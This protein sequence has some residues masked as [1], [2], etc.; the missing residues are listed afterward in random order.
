[1]GFGKHGMKTGGFGGG[2][3]FEIRV[4]VI[5][6]SEK[7]DEMRISSNQI[8][9]DLE[10]FQTQPPPYPK[11]RHLS[12]YVPD[13]RRGDMNITRLAGVPSS[14]FT[15]IQLIRLS[16]QG[17]GAI[18][19]LLAAYHERKQYE[20]TMA[21]L[22][23]ASRLWS[24]V[25]DIN[26]VYMYVLLAVGLPANVL[27]LVTILTMH[28]VTPVAILIASLA[29]VDGAALIGKF[30]GMQIF[31]HE[32]HV[33]SVGC[34]MEFLILFMSTMA[35]WILAYISVER[36]VS[37][38][39][40]TKKEIWLKK[41]NIFVA[42]AATGSALLVIFASVSL[43]MRD[44]VRS[45]YQCGVYAEFYWFY[46]YVWYWIN[47]TLFL[48]LPCSMVLPCTAMAVARFLCRAADR[49][50]N[51]DESEGRP[52]S[53]RERQYEVHLTAMMLIA[54]IFFILLCL[55]ACVYYL[56]YNNSDDM[57]VE[58][59]WAIFEQVQFLLVDS[60]HAINF[61]IYFASSRVFRH[62]LFYLLTCRK[63]K[64]LSGE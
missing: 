8:F 52:T 4:K 22:D 34:K 42:L 51:E 63:Y 10:V 27:A 26:R 21:E 6:S 15:L 20:E 45:G 19:D 48:F 64:N 3:A 12:C 13:Y 16:F 38:W 33:G 44:S 18:D 50:E 57:I 46:K 30:I 37:L 55:P 7:K 35:N 36:F 9:R 25:L 47:A 56:A 28:A 23:E 60:T 59:R 41:K 29:A 61:F 1:M 62:H 58:A 53:E 24:V 11:L 54:A 5:T 31:R 14:N 17:G 43:T 40:P 39:Y 49:D 32:L 2:L